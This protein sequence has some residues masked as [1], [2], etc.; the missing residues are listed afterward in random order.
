MYWLVDFWSLTAAVPHMMYVSTTTQMSKSEMYLVDL[1]ETE[2]KVD[3]ILDARSVIS[4]SSLEPA[5]FAFSTVFIFVEQVR[6]VVLVCP[7][8]KTAGYTTCVTLRIKKSYFM[9]VLCFTLMI[10]YRGVL[11]SA[12]F[13]SLC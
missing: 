9:R 3:A 8:G 4:R 6:R 1:T 11:V 2:H 12:V 7:K 13:L 10:G 5:P